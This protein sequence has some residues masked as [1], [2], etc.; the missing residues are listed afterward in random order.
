MHQPLAIYTIHTAVP[1]YE[2]DNDD[3]TWSDLNVMVRPTSIGIIMERLERIGVRHW[4]G[5]NIK[6]K[7]NSS[8]SGERYVSAYSHCAKLSGGIVS[9]ANSECSHMEA[10]LSG[11]M[12]NGIVAPVDEC[13]GSNDTTNADEIDREIEAKKAE[14]AI[15]E[16]NAELKNASTPLRIEQVRE[17]IVVQSAFSFDYI[18]LLLIVTIISG[19]GLITD[20]SVVIVASMLV[21]PIMAGARNDFRWAH[22]RLAFGSGIASD[23]SYI[24]F[25][26]R[27]DW[28]WNRG[29]CRRY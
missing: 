11:G 5:V 16:T 12:A 6:G 18:V 20:N 9:D 21:S 17:Q 24:S 3:S 1:K 23:R 7:I 19:V 2:T 22:L 25:D 8:V 10:S 15:K 4:H 14:R 27:F 26:L 29:N 28:C 13:V